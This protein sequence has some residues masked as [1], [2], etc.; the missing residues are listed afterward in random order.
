M[1]QCGPVTVFYKCFH[2]R[3]FIYL[4]T[5][6]ET[7]HDEW[8]EIGCNNAAHRRNVFQSASCFHGDLFSY[9]KELLGKNSSA[10]ASTYNV[11][12]FIFWYFL[13]IRSYKAVQKIGPIGLGFVNRLR[14]LPCS[15]FCIFM[16]FLVSF[17]AS[18]RPRL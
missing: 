17:F 14:V 12:M 7:S 18:D 10:S 5:E 16:Y 4:L 3:A 15:L 9:I 6:G 8:L 2:L 1:A 13:L 11:R